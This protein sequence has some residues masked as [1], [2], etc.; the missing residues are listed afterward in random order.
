M[1]LFPLTPAPIAMVFMIPII[2]MGLY[3]IFY[4]KLN[5]FESYK[6]EKIENQIIKITNIVLI[7]LIIMAIFKDNK[8]SIIWIGF[9]GANIM[10]SL[11]YICLI[12]AYL[13]LRDKKVKVNEDKI[14]DVS[15]HNH[16]RGFYYLMAATI[17]TRFSITAYLTHTS[18]II[19]RIIIIFVLLCLGK[20]ELNKNLKVLRN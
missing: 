12:A 14:V 7:Y 17:L 3:Y 19:I 1:L 13:I 10:L 15:L 20:S 6:L 18:S 9:F 2:F 8:D 4:I 11:L 5:K 16:K